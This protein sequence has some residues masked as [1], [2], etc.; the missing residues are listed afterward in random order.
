MRKAALL[1]L[2][3][4]VLSA[5][6]PT[7]RYQREV[8][9]AGKGPQRLE[10]DLALLGGVASDF[11]DFR[12]KDAEGRDVP[13][14]V[15][16]PASREPAWLSGQMLSLPTTKEHSGFELDLGK[17]I[18]TSRLRVEGL[19]T[20]F[21]KRFRL[22]GSGDRTRWTELVAEGSLFDLPED[23]LKL[24]QIDLP[25]GE[26]RYLRLVWDDASSARLSLPR[27]AFVQVQE[28]GAAPALANLAFQRAPS[29]PGTSRF[30]LRLPGPRLPITALRLVVGGVGPL[31]REARVL[32]GRLHAGNLAPREL[33][34]ARLRRTERQGVAASDLRIPME[35]PEGT[36]LELRV[37]DGSNP[38]LDLLGVRAELPPQ[39]WI[40][41]ESDGRPAQAWFGNPIAEAPRYDLEALKDQLQPGKAA[42][43]QWG[44]LSAPP[45]ARTLALQDPGP[46]ANLDLAGFKVRRPVPDAQPGLAALVLDAHV[47]ATS[48]SLLDLRILDKENRQIPYLLEQRDGPLSVALVWPSRKAKERSSE[49]V[50]DLTQAG[51]AEGRV[52]LE[53]RTRVF[54]RLVRLREEGTAEKEG[55]VLSEGVWSHDQPETEPPLLLLEFSSLEGRRVVIT[56]DEGD[57]QPL[58]ITRATLL[59]PGWRLRFFHP[60]QGLTL[61]YDRDLGGPQYDLALLA[62]R[63][64]AAPTRELELTALGSAP[65]PPLDEKS[66]AATKVFW[67]TLAGAVAI[68][69]VLL[70]RLLRKPQDG[71]SS[72]I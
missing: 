60:G 12:I 21:L 61:L 71:P 72:D 10:A 41:F 31:L 37:D 44:P 13:Y 48:R 24:L 11:R 26:Y 33:G 2:A 59:L 25:E 55:R 27:R 3:P 20:P 70:S 52:V 45:A 63:L 8:H 39:P 67:A 36:E 15:V 23:G 35:T 22:E 69:L 6:D 47:L 28:P 34:Q 14:V 56:V 32:E 5:T 42:P 54:R 30:T 58:S 16:P 65:L 57:N 19:R 66:P 53:T 38:P 17:A 18:R 29:E 51:L 46:G 4:L 64:R 40:Y 9:P 62:D 1:L 7:F 68:L 43:A 50:L 49:Y